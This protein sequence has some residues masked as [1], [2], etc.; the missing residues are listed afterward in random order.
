[1][2]YSIFYIFSL[3]PLLLFAQNKQNISLQ[4]AVRMGL[5]ESKQLKLSTLK[6]EAYQIKVAQFKNST[7]PTVALSSNYTRL[8]NNIQPFTIKFP[9]GAEQALNPQILNQFTNRLSVQEMI[10]AGFRANNT[11]KSM[12]YM[13]KATALDYEKDKVEISNNIITSYLGLQKLKVSL[14]QLAESRKLL[15][16]R[17]QDVKNLESAGMALKNDVLKVELAISNLAQTQTEVETAV[18]IANYNLAMMLGLATDTEIVTSDTALTSEKSLQ[19]LDSYTTNALENRAEVKAIGYRQ[20]AAVYNIKVA[21]GNYYPT[22][23]V[24]ANYYVN[25]PNQRMF[26]QQDKFKDTWDAG[27]TLNWN[28]TNLY[29]TGKLTE[30]ATSNLRQTE[31]SKEQ[32]QDGIKMEVNAQYQ[33]YLAALKKIEL[34]QM[35]IEQATEN[36]RLMKNRYDEKLVTMTDLLEADTQLLQSQINII[37]AKI[38]AQSLYYK[39]M[40]AIGQ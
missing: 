31:I 4:D 16:A 8:S 23:S 32:L 11:L 40:K 34:Y 36:Q 27:I 29:N 26:P 33:A 38:D 35:S 18:K 22:L 24:G 15:D 19:S 7:I 1:M 39:L 28:I 9:N 13:E 5:E 14:T 12:D 30:E 21:Q 3:F 17:L 20:Q 25:R 6:S 2:K 37:S 10:F